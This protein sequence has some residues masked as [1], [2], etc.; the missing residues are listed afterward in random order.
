M[1]SRYTYC[2]DVWAVAE[3]AEAVKNVFLQRSRSVG[4]NT[5]HLMEIYGPK[6]QSNHKRYHTGTAWRNWRKTCKPG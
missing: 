2:G 4:E 3:K 6:N 1:L 5:Y